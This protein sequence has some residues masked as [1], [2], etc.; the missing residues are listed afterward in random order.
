MI[1]Y[2][3]LNDWTA[4]HRSSQS[5][6]QF[7]CRNWRGLVRARESPPSSGHHVAYVAL[8][9]NLEVTYQWILVGMD[10]CTVKEKELPRSVQLT[11]NDL[12]I[13]NYFK[14]YTDILPDTYQPGLYWSYHRH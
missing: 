4:H 3:S 2:S 11:D 14:V 12:M 9:K 6:A 10:G 7:H 1:I 8:P 13:Q 5:V